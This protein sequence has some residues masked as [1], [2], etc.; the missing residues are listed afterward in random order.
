MWSSFWSFS[1]LTI[2][3]AFCWREI[4]KEMRRTTVAVL[5][6][7]NAFRGKIESSFS[8]ISTPNK[9]LKR[10][11]PQVFFLKYGALSSTKIKGNQNYFLKDIQNFVVFDVVHLTLFNPAL[12]GPFNTQGGADLPQSFFLFSWTCSKTGLQLSSHKNLQFKTHF[13]CLSHLV[14]EI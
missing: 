12:F 2:W 7:T 4:R 13:W 11:R 3:V 10:D 1:H 8:N 6:P 5:Q 14:P 9:H